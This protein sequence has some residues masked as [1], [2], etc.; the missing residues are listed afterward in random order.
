MLR[1]ARKNP[2]YVIPMARPSS[3]NRDPAASGNASLWFAGKNG[4]SCFNPKTRNGENHPQE[5]GLHGQSWCAQR[6]VGAQARAVCRPP[7]KENPDQQQAIFRPR[8]RHTIIG[9]NELYESERAP[10]QSSP[11]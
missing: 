6:R 2:V 9:S 5:R 10:M 3:K 4:E 7:R 8:C 1:R 11:R